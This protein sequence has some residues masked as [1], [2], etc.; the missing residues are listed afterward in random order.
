VAAHTEDLAPLHTL[1]EL[2]PGQAVIQYQHLPAIRV[3]LRFTHHDRQLRRLLNPGP[4]DSGADTPAGTGAGE[5][6]R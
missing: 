1:R 3:R 5:E 2:P 6:A 4:G